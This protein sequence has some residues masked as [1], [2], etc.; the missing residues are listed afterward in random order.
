[1]DQDAASLIPVPSVLFQGSV[2]L[3]SLAKVRMK[4]KESNN[5]AN[6]KATNEN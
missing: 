1:M 3:G 2:L 4:M 6:R 5:K